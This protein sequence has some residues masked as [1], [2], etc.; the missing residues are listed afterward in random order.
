M[1]NRMPIRTDAFLIYD[2]ED[3]MK[4]LNQLLVLVTVVVSLTGCINPDQGGQRG[5]AEGRD[6]TSPGSGNSP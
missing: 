4:T 6:T 1:A 2:R 5:R 3:I